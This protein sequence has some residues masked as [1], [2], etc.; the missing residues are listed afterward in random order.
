MSYKEKD[1]AYETGPAWV[2]TDTS[3][4]R[5]T[6]FLSGVTHSTGDTSYSLDADG[7]SLAKARA[8]YLAKREA[9]KCVK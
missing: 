8:D 7:F 2:L 3:A 5:Y 6:V 4:G 1:I 9:A